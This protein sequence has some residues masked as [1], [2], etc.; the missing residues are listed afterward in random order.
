MLGIG[1]LPFPVWQR[2]IAPLADTG[3]ELASGDDIAYGLRAVKTEAEQ[4]VIDEAYR[5]ART[6]LEA[7]VAAIHPGTTE[8]EIAAAAESAMR[9]AGAE[10]FGIDTMVA[11]GLP[12]TSPILARSTFRVVQAD[13][14]VTVTLAPDTRATTRR[15]REPSCSGPT[16][17]SSSQSTRRVAA[18]ALRW[19]TSP[20]ALQAAMLRRR[21]ARCLTVLTQARSCRMCPFTASA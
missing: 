12:N 15:W 2:L 10:G 5:I 9:W 16:R 4:A 20:P 11:S 7:A 21:S 3:A 8:R 14:L 18:N 17:G 13:D 1:A 19:R 6:G